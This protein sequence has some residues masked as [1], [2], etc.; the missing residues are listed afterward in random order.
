MTAYAYR[1]HS[2][3]GGQSCPRQSTI[4]ACST[5]DDQHLADLLRAGFTT[6]TATFLRDLHPASRCRAQAAFLSFDAKRQMPAVRSVHLGKLA[7]YLAAEGDAARDTYISLQ[8]F[9]GPRKSENLLELS[10][11]ALDLDYYSQDSQW[12]ARVGED[13]QRVVD[14]FLA[15]C[16]M[17]GI[18]RP[19]LVTHSHGLQALWIFERP[20]PAQAQVRWKRAQKELISRF[21][22]YG[23]DNKCSDVARVFRLPG[24]RNSKNGEICRIVHRTTD[25]DG[26]VVRYNFEFMTEVL[27]PHAR[28]E[29][30]RRK[31]EREERA[32]QQQRRLPRPL[33][34]TI[35]GTETTRRRAYFS[36]VARDLLELIERRGGMPEGMRMHALFYLAV[37]HLHAGLVDIDVLPERAKLWTKLIDPQWR[38]QETAL[39]TVIEKAQRARQGETVT[40]AGKAWSPLYTPKRRTLI[41]LFAISPEEQQQLTTLRCADLSGQER[42]NA[43]RRRFPDRPQAR[44]SEERK[45]RAERARA[46]RQDGKT[47]AEIAVA[48]GVSV[49]TVHRYLKPVQ[50]PPET[51]QPHETTEGGIE[52][53][54]LGF[55]RIADPALD[56]GG[57][58]PRDGGSGRSPHLPSPTF[59]S[60]PRRSGALGNVRPRPRP[61]AVLVPDRELLRVAPE[62]PVADFIPGPRG[63][64][65]L[66]FWQKRRRWPTSEELDALVEALGLSRSPG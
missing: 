9:A 56:Y 11:L 61:P 53:G 13:P 22:A 15:L 35:R 23:A 45:E 27:L 4:C 17:E 58:S 10:C 62:R 40:Y 44:I 1:L 43:L 21:A 18:P 16:D 5:T 47:I 65:K 57:A 12:R 59:S 24:T 46:L 2:T 39:K 41:D 60:G 51:E 52:E 63:Y 31:K 19:S 64:L 34:R 14:S 29:C 8:R 66:Q 33:R 6:D 49:S 54:A 26:A 48:L 38:P 55:S 3:Q 36:Y 25:T 37:S 7:S 32:A 42:H 30:A 20:V 28:W 50:P